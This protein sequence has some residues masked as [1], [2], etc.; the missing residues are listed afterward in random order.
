MNIL[1][2]KINNLNYK[3]N[4]KYILKNITL[5]SN[6]KKI[7]IIAGNNGS[8]KTTFLKILHG[9]INSEKDIIKWK[10]YSVSQVKKNQSMV[11]QTPI[12]LNRT[13][14]E[15][16]AYVARKRNIDYKSNVEEIMKKLNIKHI[17]NTNSKFG[18]IK[19]KSDLATFDLVGFDTESYVNGSV[20]FVG[21]SAHAVHPLAGMG[22]NLGISDVIEIHSS[23]KNNKK[24]FNKKNFFLSYERKQKIVNK[25]A[26]QQLKIIEKVY[27]IEN[28]F[29]AKLIENTM[30]NINKSEFIKEK[31]VQHANNNLSF[32]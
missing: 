7:T 10:D 22:L 12:L 15:N 2:L 8:G 31:I 11:F 5:F 21:D 32:F 3:A 19:L 27:S 16:L 29:L 17:A 4:N 26:R 1:P 25:K 6:E 23:I 13:A 30:N 28:K 20:I 18:K 9:L 14:Y 24:N